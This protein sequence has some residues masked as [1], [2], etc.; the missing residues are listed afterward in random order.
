MPREE[1]IALT[2]QRLISVTFRRRICGLVPQF[3]TTINT[4]RGGPGNNM[5]TQS[6]TIALQ[7][8]EA[9]HM[10]DGTVVLLQRDEYGR[11]QSVVATEDDLRRLLAAFG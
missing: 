8:G 5:N 6:Q 9:E 11:P 7:N 2:G 4:A 3:R 10:G 1:E